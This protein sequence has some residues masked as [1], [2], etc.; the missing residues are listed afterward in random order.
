[1][2]HRITPA[3]DQFEFDFW[4]QDQFPK[5]QFQD[6]PKIVIDHRSLRRKH[7][8]HHDQKQSD[9]EAAIFRL[10]MRTLPLMAVFCVAL[11]PCFQPSPP[12]FPKDDPSL[13]MI[14]CLWVVDPRNSLPVVPP[15]VMFVGLESRR[16]YS[17]IVHCNYTICT[18]ILRV[19]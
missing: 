9:G 7:R 16:A 2:F 8:K 17:N 10:A 12:L 11:Q 15:P 5:R 3:Q 14:R 18:E 1:M 6:F 4:L 19:S 13:G